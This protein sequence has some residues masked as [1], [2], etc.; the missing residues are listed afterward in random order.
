MSLRDKCFNFHIHS[1]YWTVCLFQTN[2]V[3]L[4]L[5]PTFVG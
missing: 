1:F 2:I 5:V 4:Y 3:D